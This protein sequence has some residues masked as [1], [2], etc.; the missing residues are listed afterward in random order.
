[1]AYVKEQYMSPRKKSRN[2]T[3]YRPAKN[4]RHCKHVSVL[5]SQTLGKKEGGGG[6]LAWEYKNHFRLL[7]NSIGA[8]KNR[9]TAVT[10]IKMTG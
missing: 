7:W 2:S 4:K 9:M 5:D 3:G 6:R 1:M 8:G 10:K